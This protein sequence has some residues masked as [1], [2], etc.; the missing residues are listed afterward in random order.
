VVVAEINGCAKTVQVD[1]RGP[2]YRVSHGG[3]ESELLVVA[4]NV[5]ELTRH[6]LDK[7]EPD[8]SR[9]LLAP[10][11]GLLVRLNV[12]EGDE[13]KAGEELAIVEAMKMENSLRAEQDVII[14]DVLATEGESLAV[15]QPILEFKT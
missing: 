9:Y 4:P 7:I 13:I 1:T 8:M 15:D 11:P 12:T 3:T 2:G 6:M 10:M 14:A 5:A